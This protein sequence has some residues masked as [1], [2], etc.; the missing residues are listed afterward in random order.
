MRM[1]SLCHLI[2]KS[3]S[4]TF[5]HISVSFIILSHCESLA[6]IIRLHSV[7]RAECHACLLLLLIGHFTCLH[8]S[9]CLHSI[10]LQS[11]MGIWLGRKLFIFKVLSVKLLS[12]GTQ[13]YPYLSVFK[14]FCNTSF[15]IK[16]NKCT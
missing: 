6:P 9:A 4:H 2:S 5:L 12:V 1:V 8:S 10:A 11:P 7:S 16:V 15:P 13:Y 14:W 3:S